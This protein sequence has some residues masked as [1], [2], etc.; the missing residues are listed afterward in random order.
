MNLEDVTTLPSKVYVGSSFTLSGTIRNVAD[1]QLMNVRL[2]IQGGFPFSKTSPITSFDIGNLAPG[3]A[4]TFAIPLTVDND[5][6]NTQYTLAMK[7]DYAVYDPAVDVQ[8]AEV[9][10]GGARPHG[11]IGV[12]LEGWREPPTHER[13]HVV[14]DRN[15]PEVER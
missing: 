7:V 3:Q 14:L 4:F 1:R 6:T 12:V 15:G 9:I 10:H 5:A 2:T 11:A 8:S 13:Q